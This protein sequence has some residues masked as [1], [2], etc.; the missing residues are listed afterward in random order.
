MNR[1]LG[2]KSKSKS[3]QTE[4]EV[5][6]IQPTPNRCQTKPKQKKQSE[7]TGLN[8]IQTKMR[9]YQRQLAKKALIL[10]SL[11]FIL[12]RTYYYLLYLKFQPKP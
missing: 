4:S 5:L 3:K 7:K 6:K 11:T 2:K 9:R 8:Q 1:G 12:P 10:T